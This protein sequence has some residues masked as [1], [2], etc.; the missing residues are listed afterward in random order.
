[1]TSFWQTAQKR[2]QAVG[3]I[4]S[5]FSEQGVGIVSFIIVKIGKNFN[6]GAEQFEQKRNEILLFAP[7][8]VYF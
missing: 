2:P 5:Q 8:S 6:K 7:Y 1:M 4:A 3:V